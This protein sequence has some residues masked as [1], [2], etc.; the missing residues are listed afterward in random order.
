MCY[1][2]Y[3]M[4]IENMNPLLLALVGDSYIDLFVRTQIIGPDG[5]IKPDDVHKMAT[6]YV[7]ARA[8]SIRF[9]AIREELNEVES[10]IANRARNAK[11]NTSAKNASLAEYRNATALEAIVGYNYKVGNIERANELIWGEQK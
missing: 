2:Q 1:T 9:L 6:T 10:S 5:D 11:I 7:S 8:Q 3:S 4:K